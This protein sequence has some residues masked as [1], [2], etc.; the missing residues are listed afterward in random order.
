MRTPWARHLSWRGP[1][2]EPVATEYVT[3]GLPDGDGWRAINDAGQPRRLPR[4]ALDPSLRHLRAG[5][6][7]RVEATDAVI[8][9][10]ELP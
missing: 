7:L 8:T 5:Q 4:T 6:R 9:R 3:V 10:A 2:D 1:Y